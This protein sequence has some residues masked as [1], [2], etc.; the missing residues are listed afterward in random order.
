MTF[1]SQDDNRHS[2]D[3]SLRDSEYFLN[4]DIQAYK[5]HA[6]KSREID[7]Y[8]T[9]A[10]TAYRPF[11]IIPDIVAIDINT[12][13]GID[14]HGLTFMSDAEQ[15]RRFAHIIRTE[16]PELLTGSAANLTV[17]SSNSG[18]PAIIIK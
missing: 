10:R 4:Q 13:Y 1:K 9:G 2:F 12:K 8:K 14:I 17:G 5:D 3:V 7:Q 6:A 11:C 15:K 16:Y 18:G